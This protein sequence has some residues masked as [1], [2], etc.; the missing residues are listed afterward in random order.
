MSEFLRT[1]AGCKVPIST[2]VAS[3]AVAFFKS[4]ATSSFGREM[5][6]VR[7]YFAL[8]PRRSTLSRVS[9]MPCFSSA[10][11]IECSLASGL[12]ARCRREPVGSQAMMGVTVPFS[13]N[14]Y[15]GGSSSAFAHLR[16]QNILCASTGRPQFAQRRP[17]SRFSF[18]ACAFDCIAYYAS[19]VTSQALAKTRRI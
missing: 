7:P 9:E 14:F 16:L 13:Q 18:S 15:L 3:P 19:R 17:S 1:A 4:L 5:T 12:T 8:S 11:M 2:K 10:A 6:A